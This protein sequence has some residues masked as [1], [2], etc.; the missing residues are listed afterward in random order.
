MKKLFAMLAVLSAVTFAAPTWAA[1]ETAS[2]G[3][4][5]PAG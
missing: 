3:L 5:V 4:R 2:T 1:D